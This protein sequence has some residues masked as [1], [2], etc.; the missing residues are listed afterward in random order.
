MNNGN[1]EFQKYQF[2]LTKEGYGLNQ[3]IPFVN[4][5]GLLSFYSVRVERAYNGNDCTIS[6]ESNCLTRVIF[7]EVTV[8]NL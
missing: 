2:E 3:F 6:N 4:P 1:G 7:W 8:N 5:E